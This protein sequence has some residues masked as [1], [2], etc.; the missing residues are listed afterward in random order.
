MRFELD[1][2]DSLDSDETDTGLNA[3][4]S[5]LP[6]RTK[7]VCTGAGAELLLEM[8]LISIYFSKKS[9]ISL[10]HRDTLA[11]KTV[12]STSSSFC[13]SFS[14]LFSSSFWL[15]SSCFC[16]CFCFSSRLS[17]SFSFSSCSFSFLSFSFSFCFSF[18]FLRFLVL[19]FPVPPFL[20][21]TLLLHP[22]VSALFLVHPEVSFPSYLFLVVKPLKRGLYWA[23]GASDPFSFHLVGLYVSL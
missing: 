9:S 5:F 21:I 12:S 2:D 20:W 1:V 8:G 22:S 11:S 4:G 19:P 23:L 18:P 17:F 13:L 16:F 3:L 6:I 14:F 10:S 15:C 7:R